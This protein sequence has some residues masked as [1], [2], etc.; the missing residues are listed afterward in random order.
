MNTPLAQRMAEYA[1]DLRFEHLPPMA[2]HEVKRRLIDSVGCCRG[3][4]GCRTLRDRTARRA[5]AFIHSGAMLW[6]TQHRARSIGRLSPTAAWFDT[7]ITTIHI[8]P[9]E[10][11]HPS[12]NI[13]AAFAVAE[14]AGANGRELIAPSSSRTRH[15]AGCVMRQACAIGWDHVTYGTFSTALAAPD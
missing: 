14:A 4:V 11:A 7:S 8:S 9:K 6:G 5:N 2:V 1:A 15:S 3:R 12:D 13:P 10:P